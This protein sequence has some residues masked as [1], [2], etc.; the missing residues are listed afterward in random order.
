MN[1]NDILAKK[2][3]RL[4]KH[5]GRKLKRKMKAYQRAVQ[6]YSG[7]DT[8]APPKASKAAKVETC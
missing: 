2:Q 7:G 5:T 6:K 1:Y 4:V 3:E 8:M